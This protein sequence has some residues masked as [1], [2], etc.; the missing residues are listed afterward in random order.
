VDSY[1]TVWNHLPQNEPNPE[2]RLSHCLLIN[3]LDRNTDLDNTGTYNKFRNAFEPALH[4]LDLELLISRTNIKHFVDLTIRR[5]SFASAATSSALV[6]GRLFSHFY[7]AS[8][9][10]FT[11]LGMHPDGSH[12]ML[13]HHLHTETMETVHDAGHLTRT[14]KVE[15]LAQFPATYS[16][17]C[18]CF[19]PVAFD[20]ETGRLENCCKCEKCARTMIT[21][22]LLGSLERYKTFPR[23]IDYRTLRRIDFRKKG[24][25]IFIWEIVAL[26]KKKYNIRVILNLGYAMA[27]SYTL[28]QILSLCMFIRKH[29]KAI[30]KLFDDGRVK[31]IYHWL[32]R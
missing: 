18:V 27:R 2:Y 12:L 26:A 17:L 32:F 19:K 8:S 30:Q 4:N 15:A 10:K 31:G 23:S 16:T 24:T 11:R 7:V 9:Y 13:D 22:D 28:A 25:R 20:P 1:Y 5:Q 29:S 21:L 6:L 14:E 3:G